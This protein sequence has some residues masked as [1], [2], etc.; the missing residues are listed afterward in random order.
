MC[1][2]H[3]RLSALEQWSL[4]WDEAQAFEIKVGMETL[5]AGSAVEGASRFVAGEGRGGAF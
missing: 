3:D 4:S 2:R 1:L 5:R